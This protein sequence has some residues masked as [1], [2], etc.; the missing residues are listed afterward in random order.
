MSRL[1]PSVATEPKRDAVERLLDRVAE[2]P[3]DV[4]GHL[5]DRGFY[6]GACIPQFRETAP[7]VL[8]VI[9][10]GERMFGNVGTLI[11]HWTEY[12]MYGGSERELRLSLAVWVSCQQRM[13]GNPGPLVRAYSAC[14]QS[15][16]TLKEIEPLYQKRSAIETAFITMREAHHDY[17]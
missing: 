4:A 7:V 13:W 14:D 16:R 10:R 6:K 5:F 15:D 1:Q 11:S 8:P 17:T 12:A 3:F 9:C 2:L